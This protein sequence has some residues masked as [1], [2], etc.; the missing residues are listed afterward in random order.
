M[1]EKENEL[2]I[3]LENWSALL[4]ISLMNLYSIM[5]AKRNTMQVSFL[6]LGT[7]FI[8]PLLPYREIKTK[9]RAFKKSA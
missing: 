9:R 7:C 5:K 6:H 2:T 1:F 4:R 3:N 8:E